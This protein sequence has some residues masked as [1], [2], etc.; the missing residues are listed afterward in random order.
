V[1]ARF[2]GKKKG[3][4]EEVPDASLLRVREM[5]TTHSS[6]PV[7][8]GSG[9]EARGGEKGEISVATV[10]NIEAV[11]T[12]L[13]DRW[14]VLDKASRQKKGANRPIASEDAARS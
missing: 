9:W 1:K 11:S 13:H 6:R 4:C 5:E 7:K 3:D 14:G 8:R 12:K 10:T 2:G